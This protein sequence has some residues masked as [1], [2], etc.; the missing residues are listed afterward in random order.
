MTIATAPAITKAGNSQRRMLNMPGRNW[1]S[2]ET[3]L[4]LFRIGLLM[5]FQRCFELT[6]SQGN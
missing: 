2:L 5:F 3:I 6:A 4:I 1:F